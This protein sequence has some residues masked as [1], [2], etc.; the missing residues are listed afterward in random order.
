MWDLRN[1]MNRMLD[2]FIGRPSE[3]TF[4][5][6]WYPVVDIY[7]EKDNYIVKADLPGVKQKDIK[8]SLTGNTL[9]LRGGTQSRA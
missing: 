8:V 4:V 1:E 2:N 3:R 5:R 6:G 7:E 9:N